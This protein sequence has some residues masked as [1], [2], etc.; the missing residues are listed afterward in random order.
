VA[1]AKNYNVQRVSFTVPAGAGSYAPERL[2]LFPISDSHAGILGVMLL[3]EAAIAASTVEVWM[4]SATATD[5]TADVSFFLSSNTLSGAAAASA[6]FAMA[7]WPAV[8]LRVK[9]GG[10]AGSL[11][12]NAS[13]D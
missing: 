4:A 8:Q 11:I 13:S 12:V 7:S 10:T 1:L 9:S 3:I 2:T 5:Y 6:I